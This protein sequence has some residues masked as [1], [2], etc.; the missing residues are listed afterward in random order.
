MN[1]NN[2]FVALLLDKSGSM[3]PLKKSALSYISSQIDNIR[4]LQKNNNIDLSIYF[5]NTRLD[6]VDSNYEGRYNCAG[7]TALLDSV[8]ILV[9]ELKNNKDGYEAYLINVITDGEENSSVI[10]NGKQFNKLLSELDK[11]ERWTIVFNLPKGYKKEFC[12]KFSIPED[13]VREWEISEIGMEQSNYVNTVGTQQ[14]FTA[15]QAGAT[16]VKCFYKDIDLANVDKKNINRLK[17]ISNNFV[18]YNVTKEE[19][20]KSFIL[21]K[22]KKDYVLGSCYYQL[23]K[24]EKIQPSKNVLLI[25]KGEDKILGGDKVKEILGINL[26][27]DVKVNPK[28]L[29]DYEIYVQSTSHNRKLVRGTKV[30]VDLTVIKPANHT[31]DNT[32]VS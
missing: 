8:H 10:T 22:T 11:E 14:Y 27:S 19:D 16:R 30:L 25:K 12:R 21:G 32:Y 1:N 4:H 15:R 20:I 7:G 18:S 3:E 6:K 23:T 5:F 13:N 26:N 24:T 2:T 9:N 31:W 28:N 17:D 29:M